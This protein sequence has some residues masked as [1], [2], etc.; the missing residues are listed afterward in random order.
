MVVVMGKEKW[1]N[2]ASGAA[3]GSDHSR[4][5][6]HTLPF[7]EADTLKLVENMMLQCEAVKYRQD[8]IATNLVILQGGD[9][10]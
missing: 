7:K 5:G 4:Q 3:F 1:P 8:S 6:V 9:V 2:I 10:I